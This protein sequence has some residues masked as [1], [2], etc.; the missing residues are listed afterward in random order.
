MFKRIPYNPL[1]SGR[2]ARL[3]RNIKSKNVFVTLMVCS[4][5]AIFLPRWITA[6]TQRVCQAWLAPGGR[7]SLLAARA[8][9]GNRA[10]PQDG[11]GALTDQQLQ[12]MLAALSLRLQQLETENR[13]LHGIRQVIG[14]DPML[15]PARVV[16]FDS[17]GL[18]SVEIDRGTDTGVKEG[19][20]VLAT[21]PLDLLQV[22]GLDPKLTIAA[23]GIIGRVDHG[24][25]P[26]TA[27]VKLISS[28]DTNMFA[29]VIRF[30]NGRT[31]VIARVL[32]RGVP[33]QKDIL[34]AEQ[35]KAERGVEKGDFLVPDDPEKLG[36]TAPMVFGVV[37][38]VETR[39]DVR[40]LVDLTIRP[41]FDK[42]R[43]NK[44]YVLA[45]QTPN[46]DD[47]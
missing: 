2:W 47:K 46:P 21:I 7:F 5:A 32:V 41:L 10:Q 26:F 40:M 36:L 4:V 25:G 27:R 39:P 45:P 18:P 28:S 19:L 42:I 9:S 8:V 16:G 1:P 23:G 12:R 37:D 22:E 44:V 14:S 17:L 29:N 35:V 13:S 3:Y 38:K 24:V 20:P 30:V 31:Q 33:K 34:R 15:I 43:L 6:P 11:D